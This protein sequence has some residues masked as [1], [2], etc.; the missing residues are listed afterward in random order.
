MYKYCQ[1]TSGHICQ[2]CNVILPWDFFN[3]ICV[4]TAET[5]RER[6]LIA[7]YRPC[8]MCFPASFSNPTF[9]GFNDVPQ[10]KLG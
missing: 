7:F 3:C 1:V 5:G 9:S 8:V 4:N 2:R 10:G 6:A